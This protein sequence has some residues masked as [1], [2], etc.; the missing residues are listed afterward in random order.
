MKETIL[1]DGEI[2]FLFGGVEVIM[3]DNTLL[4]LLEKF[5]L[6]E[7]V[8][9]VK[10]P[11]TP[12]GKL[13]AAVITKITVTPVAAEPAKPA[14]PPCP[15]H[16]GTCAF[17]LTTKP[18]AV[19]EYDKELAREKGNRFAGFVRRV[20]WFESAQDA[21]AYYGLSKGSVSTVARTWANIIAKAWNPKVANKNQYASTKQYCGRT[22]GWGTPCSF[23]ATDCDGN[24][25]AFAYIEDLP[26]TG[27]L[28]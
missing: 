25:L 12:E 10:K 21:E 19:F 15:Y 8:D 5:G 6:I 4:G 22:A 9:N 2:A 3:N 7:K 27:F 20:K 16:D 23:T 13:L 1:R 18:V 17:G 11:D 28:V 26:K 24:T 14:C